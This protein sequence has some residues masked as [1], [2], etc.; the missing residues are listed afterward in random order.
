[1]AGKAEPH[2]AEGAEEKQK[3]QRGVERHPEP[4]KAAEQKQSLTAPP[5]EP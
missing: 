4:P 2:N 1:M 3:R 5:L